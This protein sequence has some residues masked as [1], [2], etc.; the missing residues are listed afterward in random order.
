MRSQAHNHVTWHDYKQRGQALEGWGSLGG[1]AWINNEKQRACH[2]DAFM[3][4]D[5]GFVVIKSKLKALHNRDI[6]F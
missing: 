6:A 2:A 4:P 5:G 3:Y 1:Q